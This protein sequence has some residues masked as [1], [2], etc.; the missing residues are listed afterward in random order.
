MCMCGNPIHDVPQ[1]LLAAAPFFAP[2]Y[3]QAR[4]FLHRVLLTF[5]RQHG[6]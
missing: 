2:F 4:H 3:V 1:W 5:R 6:N